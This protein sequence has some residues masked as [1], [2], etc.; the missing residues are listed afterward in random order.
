MQSIWI[1]N[2]YGEKL[3]AYLF[4]PEREP[5]FFLIV[6]HGFRGAKENGGR[7]YQFASRV[8]DLDG[9]VLAFDF[10]GSGASEGNYARM[11]LT[12]QADDLRSVIDY[13]S[14]L[15]DL[16]LVLLGRSFGGVLLCGE[17]EGITAAAYNIVVNSIFM[18]ELLL[19]DT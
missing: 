18:T 15:Y 16:P 3:A 19:H 6:C 12:R 14:S 5:R 13:I 8:N 7:I 2:K 1:N 10:S 17:A 11:T 9:G 4:L